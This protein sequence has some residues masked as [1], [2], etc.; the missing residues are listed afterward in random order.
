MSHGK[1]L[2]WGVGSCSVLL[3]S[4]VSPKDTEMRTYVRV[5]GVTSVTEEIL[6]IL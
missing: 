6:D 1:G 3:I 5:E 4:R 2:C